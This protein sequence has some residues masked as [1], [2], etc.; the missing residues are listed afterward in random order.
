MHYLWQQI[1]NSDLIKSL[2]KCYQTFV[3]HKIMILELPCF[4]WIPH[5]V[6]VAEARLL[7]WVCVGSALYGGTD[8]FKRLAYL[9]LEA[10]GGRVPLVPWTLQPSPPPLY[11]ASSPFD[12]LFYIYHFNFSIFSFFFILIV[13]SFLSFLLALFIL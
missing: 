7:Y 2:K 10:H 13:F 1:N 12:S 9:I 3:Q 8:K 5:F 4:Y 6:S 11:P